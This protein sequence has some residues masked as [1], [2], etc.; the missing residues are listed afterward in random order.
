[1][2]HFPNCTISDLYLHIFDY[3]DLYN[4]RG[5]LE[6]YVE[7]K[8]S[9]AVVQS[10]AR[11][12]QSIAFTGAKK[13]C[14]PNDNNCSILLSNIF[15]AKLK[16]NR[17]IINVVLQ[18]YKRYFSCFVF[19]FFLGGQYTLSLNLNAITLGLIS[20]ECSVIYVM[21]RIEWT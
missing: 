3:Y 4:S 1:M 9:S 17:I 5:S 20:C 19:V 18:S 6:E 15:A 16:K 13:T 12:A 7:N 21:D 8:S 2:P 10:F 14:K 11:S